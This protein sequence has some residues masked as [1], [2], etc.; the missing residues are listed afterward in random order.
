MDALD[1][2]VLNA[3]FLFFVREI[4]GVAIVIFFA[5]V[6]TII[7]A[8]TKTPA[9]AAVGLVVGW[10]VAIIWQIIAVFLIVG[11]VLNIIHL[12]SA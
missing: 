4:V 5:V 7:G 3:V 9:I 2:A 12:M 11:D 10:I 6:G 1:S 8:L